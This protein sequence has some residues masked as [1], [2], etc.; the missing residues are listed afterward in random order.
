MC[1][2]A[3]HGCSD[4]LVQ[5]G[6]GWRQLWHPAQR[7]ALPELGGCVPV[8]GKERRGRLESQRP[9]SAGDDDGDGCA[10]AWSRSGGGGRAVDYVTY[11]NA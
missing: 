5:D 11:Y 4:R 7:T 9:V 6:S 3:V 10:S 1:R 8:A 2:T